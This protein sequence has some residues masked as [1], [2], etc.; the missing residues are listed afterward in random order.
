MPK[1]VEVDQADIVVN[2]HKYIVTHI[3]TATSGMWF[4]IQDVCEVWAAV[5]IDL[6]GTTA[7]QTLTV[8]FAAIDAVR[9]KVEVLDG[10]GTVLG[11]ASAA[12]AGDNLVLSSVPITADGTYTIR[13]TSLDGAG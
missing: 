4:T 3:P 12:A 11:T 2:G 10:S 7:A 13:L 1:K 6:D 8:T 9:A 5:A